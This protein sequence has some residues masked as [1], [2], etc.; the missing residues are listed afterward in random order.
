MIK[1]A[2]VVEWDRLDAL[3]GS[4]YCFDTGRPAVSTRLMVALHYL[5]YTYNL[6]DEDIVEGRVENPYWQAF[7]G[8]KFFE[9]EIP[10]E[11]SRMTRW[12]KRNGETGAEEILKEPIHAGLMTKAVKPHQLKRVNLETTVQE[13]KLR[14]PT[15]ARL[16]DRARQRLVH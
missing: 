6:N 15:D 7:S 4:T 3:F 5:K 9:H 1:L 11:P 13:K 12:R 8:I 16:Y 14:F 10:I 2:H